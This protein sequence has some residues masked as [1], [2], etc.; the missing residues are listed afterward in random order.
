MRVMWAASGRLGEAH[1]GDWPETA[2][3]V[4][5][6]VAGTPGPAVRAT[7]ERLWHVHPLAWSRLADD[8]A[9]RLGMLAYPD[10]VVFGLRGAPTMHPAPLRIALGDRF[11]VTVRAGPSPVDAVWT[12][13]RDTSALLEGPDRALYLLLDA[14]LDGFQGWLEQLERD[15]EDIHRIMLKHPYRDLAERILRCRREFLAIR[16]VLAPVREVTAI[17]AADDFAFSADQNHPYL[18]D[19][20]DRAAELLDEADATRDGLGGTVEAYTSMQSNEINK[21]MKFL[22]ILSVLGLPA[23]TIASIYG[24]NFDIPETHWPFGYAYSLA[25]M[26]SVTASLLWY[27]GRHGWFR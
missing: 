24:M 18:K 1:G 19:L 3:A 5:V 16:R 25:L 9:G 10:A 7:L 14:V 8:G 23:T 20:A 17:L 4:W 22:T 6:D 11:L 12:R 2:E 15:Y 21:V 13:V 26:A 27:M